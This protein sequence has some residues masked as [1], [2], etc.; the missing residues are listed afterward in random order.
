M[1]QAIDL[2]A[3]AGGLSLGL[4]S[5]GWKVEAAVEFD[6]AAIATHEANFPGVQ[7][8]GDDIRKVCFKKFRDIDLIAGGP[9]C[10]P[11]SVSGKRL[12]SFDVRDM[13]PEFVRVVEEARPKAFLME[14][15]AGLKAVKFNAYL[16]DRIRAGIDC[17]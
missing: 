6:R 8:I 17:C 5:A 10:Q 2:F 11:F 7:H 9:P 12:G 13:V 16:E 1:L 15:V 14:N 4:K 3:G